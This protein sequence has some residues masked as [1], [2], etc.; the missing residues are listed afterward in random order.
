MMPEIVNR[1]GILGILGE[2]DLKLLLGCGELPLAEGLYPA[3]KGQLRI[4]T[5]R[6][7]RCRQ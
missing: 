7:R 6:D 2:H 5:R 4:D 3:M 1:R